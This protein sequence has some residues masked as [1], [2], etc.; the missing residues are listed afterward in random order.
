MAAGADGHSVNAAIV[1]ENE[2]GFLR[3]AEYVL[4]LA[5]AQPF[6]TGDRLDVPG[7]IGWGKFT[8]GSR[9]AITLLKAWKQTGEQPYLDA[10]RLAIGPQYGANPMSMSFVTGIGE[11]YPRN[12]TCE[13]CLADEVEEP[14]PGIPIFGVFAH[15]SNS[16]QRH[17]ETRRRHHL[18]H[19]GS[20]SRFE[21]LVHLKALPL[22]S[23][24]ARPVACHGEWALETAVVRPC[25][26]RSRP[27]ILQDRQPRRK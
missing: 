18:P 16:L 7:W 26:A 3:R 27:P 12:P 20:F 6:S 22:H 8:Y 13:V 21:G 17:A 10:A 11:R 15:L 24:Q 9:V 1:Q 14:Y 4:R 23:R 5:Q 2:R 25:L 19:Q